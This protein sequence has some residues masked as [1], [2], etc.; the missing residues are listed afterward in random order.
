MCDGRVY[1]SAANVWRQRRAGEAVRVRCTPGLGTAEWKRGR[2]R[3]TW[4]AEARGKARGRLGRCADE[5]VLSRM[6]PVQ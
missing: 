1:G 2:L 4:A 5:V 6:P 3:M